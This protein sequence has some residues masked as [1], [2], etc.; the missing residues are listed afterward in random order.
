[1][2]GRVQAR[3]RRCERRGLGQ[4][5]A[6]RSRAGRSRASDRESD[7]T[8]QRGAKGAA[9]DILNE[10]LEAL[11]QEKVRLKKQ[12]RAVPPVRSE[13][14][15][16]EL[17][18]A[19]LRELMSDLS[20][21]LRGNDRDATRARDIVRSMIDSVTI[22]PFED[23]NCLDRRGV[24]RSLGGSRGRLGLEG[25]RNDR[26]RTSFLSARDRMSPRPTRPAAGRPIHVRV[27]SLERGGTRR[28]L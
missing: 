8:G 16:V 14:L 21:A 11:A 26:G 1:M 25:P 19:R 10:N 20:D 6:A 28:D 3:S 7:R 5:T 22:T 13:P 23:T 12:I 24:G 2:P 18:Q 9:A 4:A 15:T 27:A 17:V